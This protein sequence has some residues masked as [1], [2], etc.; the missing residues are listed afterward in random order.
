M[1]LALF[2]Y[3]A[4][5]SSNLAGFLI[6]VSVALLVAAFIRGLVVSDNNSRIENGWPGTKKKF[7]KWLIIVPAILSSL[8]MIIPS[9]R[10]MY[11]MA[12]AY[13]SQSVYQS[14]IGEDVR[15]IVKLKIKEYLKE[16]QNEPKK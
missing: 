15:N 2:V 8:A 16:M 1:E 5:I 14:E 7:E 3:L 6:A 4:A 10:T 9:E 13:I 12:G 11:T